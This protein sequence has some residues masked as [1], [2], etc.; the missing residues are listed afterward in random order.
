MNRKISIENYEEWMVDHLEGN[1]SRAEQAVLMQFLQV[2]PELKPELEMFGQT[3]LQ[4][5][6]QITFAGKEMLKKQ[7]STR[8]IGMRTW[9]KY[10]I[11]IA[12]ALL[13]FIGVKFLNV[14]NTPGSADRYSAKNITMPVFAFEQKEQADTIQ[15]HTEKIAH[16]QAEI[17]FAEEKKKVN[18]QSNEVK[19][20]PHDTPELILSEP[21][22][23]ERLE[24][25]SIQR[26]DVVKHRGRIEREVSESYQ[27]YADAHYKVKPSR[28]ENNS[29]IDKYNNT[30]AFAE[31]VGDMLGFTQKKDTDTKTD[32]LYRETHI[33]IFDLEY[34]NR[35]KTDK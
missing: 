1:L 9:Q 4:P 7:E 6:M 21:G 32:D 10:S 28:K 14:N 24:F 27:Q 16:P 33:K 31:T 3:F 12:A 20:T 34:Y 30:V 25:A 2:H 13:V 18:V 5:D 11:G 19:N 8:I 23:T 29:I 26:I 15:N 22:T 35:K 17:Y